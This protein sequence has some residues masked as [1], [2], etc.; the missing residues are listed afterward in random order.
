MAPCFL[1]HLDNMLLANDVFNLVVKKIDNTHS[2]ITL[3]KINASDIALVPPDLTVDE[4]DSLF[5]SV[6]N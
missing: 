5:L 2:Q 1:D 4:G 6:S 3:M